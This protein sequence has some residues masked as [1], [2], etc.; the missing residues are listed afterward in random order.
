MSDFEDGEIVSD[1][2]GDNATDVGLNNEDAPYTPLVRPAP[3]TTPR[4]SSSGLSALGH[5]TRPRSST[6][7]SMMV[8]IGDMDN[9]DDASSFTLDSFA[10]TS[11]AANDANI[12]SNA[13]AAQSSDDD[14]DDDDQNPLGQSSDSDSSDCGLVLKGVEVQAKSSRN[15]K[16]RKK[17]KLQAKAAGQGGSSKKEIMFLLACSSCISYT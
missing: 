16:Q 1:G 7:S 17:L 8:N 15:S 9:L 11:N 14:D 6:N 2:E 3:T 4:G 13:H 12:T 5:I 10:S